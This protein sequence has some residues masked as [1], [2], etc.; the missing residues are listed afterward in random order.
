[1]SGG[2]TNVVWH[3]LGTIES[4]P[5]SGVV[6]IGTDELWVRRFGDRVIVTSNI[7][8]HK[9]GPLSEGILKDDV[10]ECPWH[11]YQFN[12]KTGA[13]VKDACPSLRVY[14]TYLD[15]GHLL[16]REKRP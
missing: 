11:G 6:D 5:Q 15:Q 3:N 16:V 7:C 9:M 1:M 2:A 8:P 14:E 4:I 12:T 10:V 13:A